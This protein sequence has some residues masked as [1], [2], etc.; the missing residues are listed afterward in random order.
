MASWIQ[1]PQVFGGLVLLVASPLVFLLVGYCIQQW[2]VV[3]TE[4]ARAEMVYNFFGS[5]FVYVEGI[6]LTLIIFGS[7]KHSVQLTLVGTGVYFTVQGLLYFGTK[8]VMLKFKERVLSKAARVADSEWANAALQYEVVSEED[9]ESAED[10]C[11]DELSATNTY[12]DLHGSFAKCIGKFVAQLVM[13]W[14]FFIS[15]CEIK[16]PR[17]LTH[18]QSTYF[19]AAAVLSVVIRPDVSSFFNHEWV[20][21]WRTYFKHQNKYDHEFPVL[22]GCRCFCSWIVNHL[23][24]SVV[25]TAFPVVVLSCSN[26]LEF[27]KDATAVLFIT[28]L[29]NLE[30][31]PEFNVKKSKVKKCTSLDNI[32]TPPEFMGKTLLGA[33]QSPHG[34]A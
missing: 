9:S 27:V 33:V 29:D 8:E 28:S 30:T 22:A 18:A 31:P 2:K 21:F 17:E 20:G 3:G 25:Y 16:F 19:I 24:L 4:D 5:G 34:K 26:H 32:E 13:G 1:E 11:P 10:Q 6:A 23:L 12:C 15:A 14:F 7:A